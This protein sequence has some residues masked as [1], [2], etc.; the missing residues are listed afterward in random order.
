MYRYIEEKN[1]EEAEKIIDEIELLTRNRN[2]DTVR[3]RMLVRKGK[4][5][6]ASNS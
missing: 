4:R 2:R 5:V 6:N 3:G 1:Y